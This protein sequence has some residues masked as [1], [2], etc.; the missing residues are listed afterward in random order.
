MYFHVSMCLISRVLV[1]VAELWSQINESNK[2]AA[3]AEQKF[4]DMQSRVKD[5]SAD[6]LRLTVRRLFF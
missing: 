3:D 1:S 4:S 2:R 5:M 6:N